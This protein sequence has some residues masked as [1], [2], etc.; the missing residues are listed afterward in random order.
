MSRGDDSTWPFVSDYIR[1]EEKAEVLYSVKNEWNLY[2][3]Q[4]ING[5]YRFLLYS[6]DIKYVAYVSTG[7]GLS[8]PP[9]YHH[10]PPVNSSWVQIT[11]LWCW[12]W[13]SCLFVYNDLAAQVFLSSSIT[14]ET[15]LTSAVKQ[16][17]PELS[18]CKPP[19]RSSSCLKTQPPPADVWSCDQ[20]E[21]V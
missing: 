11:D 6:D 7:H 19:E 4:I 12:E 16:I 1:L 15:A 2:R 3:F 13:L 9:L 8:P 18:L 20:W 17:T 10:T 5:L 21:P 14:P